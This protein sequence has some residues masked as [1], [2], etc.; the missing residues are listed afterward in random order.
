MNIKSIVLFVVTVGLCGLIGVIVYNCIPKTA[1]VDNQR[2]F[3]AFQGRK[4]LE[5]RLEQEFNRKKLVMDS[6]GLQIK[7]LQ[8]TTAASIDQQKQLQVMLQ[9]YQQMQQDNQNYY[10]YKSQEYTEVIWK[11]I[12]AYTRAYGEEYNYDYVF[13]IAGSGSL[14]FGKQHYD[15]TD[16]VIHF[17][18]KRYA[19]K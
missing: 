18:N 5:D 17:V 10:Q 14:M 4:E 7:S 15:I 11:Q 8:Q 1:F 6:L 13:G 12:S 16:D 3:N 19:G 2:L 9:R